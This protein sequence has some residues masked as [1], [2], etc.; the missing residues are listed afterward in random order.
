MECQGVVIALPCS[1]LLTV[2]IN[3]YFKENIKKLLQSKILLIE[4]PT[5]AGTISLV[6]RFKKSN[7]MLLAFLQ[8]RDF[9]QNQSLLYDDV[10]LL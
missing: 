7:K 9:C 2:T 5:P 1:N 8:L 4:D 3:I 10:K 6:I